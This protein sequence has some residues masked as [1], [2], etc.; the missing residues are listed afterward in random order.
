MGKQT[1]AR[2]GKLFGEANKG[3]LSITLYDTFPEDFDF[4]AEPLMVE[5]DSLDVPLWCESF[6]RRGVSGANVRF[7]DFD[8]TRRAEELLG[9]ELFIDLEEEESDEFYMEDLIGF[10]VRA[11]KLKGE[12][13]DYYDSEHN[14]LFGIDFGEGERLI[15][16]T[17]EFIAGIDFDKETIKMILPEGL[18][19]L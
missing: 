19:E 9:K 3:G 11:G 12:I 8:T 7:A 17:E 2:V 18:L 10:K 13:V 16:A 6:E 4:E 1:V 15:P 14:P 5:I